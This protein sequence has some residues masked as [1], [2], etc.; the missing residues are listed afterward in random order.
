MIIAFDG[1]VWS[2]P[3]EFWTTPEFQDFR[4]SEKMYYLCFELLIMQTM[5]IFRIS[6]YFN[7][8]EEVNSFE[9]FI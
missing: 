1:G 6:K 7:M 3:L 9:L 5:M 8:S 2:P 4:K